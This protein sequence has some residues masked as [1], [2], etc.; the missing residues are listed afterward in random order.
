MFLS[1]S[2]PGAD[3]LITVFGKKTVNIEGELSPILNIFMLEPENH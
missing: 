1:I 3:V 2:N